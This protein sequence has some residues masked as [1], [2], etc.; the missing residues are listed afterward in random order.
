M[1]TYGVIYVILS[2]VIK[3]TIRINQWINIIKHFKLLNSLKIQIIHRINDSITYPNH[4]YKKLY[5]K[6]QSTLV[7][8]I[9]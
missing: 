3:I 9:S 1:K 5:Q 2:Q 8:N 6:L 4:H 7:S